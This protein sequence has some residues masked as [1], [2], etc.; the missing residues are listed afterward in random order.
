MSNISYP[1]PDSGNS[2]DIEGSLSINIDGEI[3]DNELS[4]IQKDLTLDN[5]YFEKL[6]KDKK[7]QIIH[8]KSPVV[9]HYFRRLF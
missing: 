7:A 8:K 9:L 5:E 1:H 2:D 3:K 4:I 6:I